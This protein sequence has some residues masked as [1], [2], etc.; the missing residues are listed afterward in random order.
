[1]AQKSFTSTWKRTRLVL[2]MIAL[3][4]SFAG[5]GCEIP[6]VCALDEEALQG[7]RERYG[8]GEQFYAYG[9]LLAKWR[10][11]ASDE[12]ALEAGTTDDG[13]VLFLS[14]FD[15]FTGETLFYEGKSGE[16]LGLITFSDAIDPLCYGERFW[17]AHWPYRAWL[18]NRVVTEVIAEGWDE[19]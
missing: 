3:L 17:P 12:G 11:I 13:D 18:D 7:D 15:G 4:G 19:P 5:T 9:T 8:D 2:A 10:G 1:M 16:F 14:R 6:W